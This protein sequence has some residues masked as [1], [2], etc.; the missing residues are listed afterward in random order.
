MLLR[1]G[2]VHIPKIPATEPL[3]DECAHFLDCITNDAR[4]QSDGLAGLRL[5][6]VLEA[7]QHSLRHGSMAVPVPKED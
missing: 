7:A 5:V 2:D 3:R 1:A 4:C 6:K